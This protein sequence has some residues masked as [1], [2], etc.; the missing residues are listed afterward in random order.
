MRKS[1]ALER[2][3]KL[4]Q[5][6]ESDFSPEYLNSREARETWL[7]QASRLAVDIFGLGDPLLR[8]VQPLSLLSEE[9]E[10]RTVSLEKRRR[11]GDEWYTKASLWLNRLSWNIANTSKLVGA[12]KTP[13]RTVVPRLVWLATS[14]S[15]VLIT[16][17]VTIKYADYQA[18]AAREDQRRLVSAEFRNWIASVPMRQ[19]QSFSMLLATLDEQGIT[20]SDAGYWRSVRSWMQRQRLEMD[21]ARALFQAR[22]SALG[23]DPKVFKHPT[24]VTVRPPNAPEALGLDTL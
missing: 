12:R 17:L 8:S 13:E 19:G 20:D 10:R 21:A 2:L 9:F 6:F 16:Y 18:H 5:R 24:R 7:T 3:N 15:L 1:E 14:I 23:G 4:H 11:K 22:I